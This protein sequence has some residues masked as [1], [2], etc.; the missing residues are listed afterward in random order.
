MEQELKIRAML[1]EDLPPA[2]ELLGKAFAT[3]PDTLAVYQGKWDPGR[4]MRIVFQTTFRYSPGQIYVA[5]LDHR[6]VGAMR[7]IKWPACQ[8]QNLKMI[9]GMIRAAGGLGPLKRASQ[10]HRIWGKYNPQRPHWH[11]GPIGVDPELQGKG[12][13]SRMM[14]F[15]CDIIDQSGIEAFHETDRPENVPFYKRFG[16]KVVAEEEKYGVRYWFFLRSRSASATSSPK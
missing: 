5:E 14:R 6:V 12:I 7:F 10:I 1:R 9:P 16:F 2:V 11:L 3:N 13:G 8:E 15:Y 4:R